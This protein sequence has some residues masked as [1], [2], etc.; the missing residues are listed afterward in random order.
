MLAQRSPLR[1]WT[2][3]VD[4]DRLQRYDDAHLVTFGPDEGL[5]WQCFYNNPDNKTIKFGE[6]AESNEMCFLWAYYYPSAG[7]FIST[8]CMR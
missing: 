1:R 5:R 4:L 2:I 8:E 6:S 3:D 7:R